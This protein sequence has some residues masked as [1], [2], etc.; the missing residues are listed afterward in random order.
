MVP[1]TLLAL[2]IA[3]SG[4]LLTT[5]STPSLLS[6]LS[7]LPILLLWI[8]INLLICG[9]ANQRLPSAIIEDSLN[10]SWRPIPSGRITPDSARRLLFAILPLSLVLSEYLG[11]SQETLSIVALAWVYNDLEAANENFHL[12]N[13]INAL[14]IAA[15]SAG[16]IV[17]LTGVSGLNSMGYGWL[18]IL[19]AAICSTISILDLPDIAGDSARGRRTMPIVYGHEVARWGLAVP[20][21]LWSAACP[22]CLGVGVAGYVF[23]VCLGL[24]LSR[25]LLVF[26]TQKRDELSEKLWCVWCTMLYCLPLFVNGRA[27]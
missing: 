11:N 27:S 17:A 19:T 26:R 1:Q 12:R 25:H 18:C 15:F 21:A 6:T 5:N 22:L 7:H 16:S 8:S 20:I 4:P 2:S 24:G 23:S 14:A 9:I 10:K 3:L 13:L